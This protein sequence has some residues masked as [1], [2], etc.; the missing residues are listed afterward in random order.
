MRAQTCR[1]LSFIFVRVR[2]LPGVSRASSALRNNVIIELTSAD[3]S[4]DPRSWTTT[5]A[6]KTSNYGRRSSRV[7]IVHGR[8]QRHRTGHPAGATA[9]ILPDVSTV[10][11][12]LT[13]P[14]RATGSGDGADV[15]VPCG[16]GENALEHRR[17][18][19]TAALWPPC[20][21][22]PAPLAS[23]WPPPEM[24]QF[25]TARRR[26][27]KPSPPPRTWGVAC[28][29]ALGVDAV[30]RDPAVRD[31]LPAIQAPP[32]GTVPGAGLRLESWPG[33]IKAL[34]EAGSP[35]PLALSDDSAPR[36]LQRRPPPKAG[37]APSDGQ[38]GTEGDGLGRRTIAA[39]DYTKIPMDHGRLQRRSR[40]PP[41][42][43][44]RLRDRAQTTAPPMT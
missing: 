19:R 18:F 8:I 34:Q 37:R 27:G 9:P 30:P 33:D 28:S 12:T 41:S 26:P 24:A 20:N 6:S 4:A 36:R 40:L 21:A 14:L 10:A 42:S 17:G 32:M 35:P 25:R 38:R 16:R 1:G 2:V 44:G 23:C 39:S 11:G 43:S 7:M 13:P 5:R 15:P 29:A 3:L 31:R 22:A